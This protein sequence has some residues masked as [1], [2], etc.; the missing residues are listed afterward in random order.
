MQHS[1]KCAEIKPPQAYSKAPLKH[2]QFHAFNEAVIIDHIE[3][4][5]VGKTARGFK[6]ILTI[7][8]GWSNYLVAV[9]TRTQKATES[10]ALIRK[11]WIERFGV[12][13]CLLADNHPNFRSHYFE[14]VLAA[15]IVRKYMANHMSAEQLVE[16][17]AVI[18][19]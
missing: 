5:K 17:S 12:P 2:I 14:T 9:P 3:P 4:E 13:Q 19:V 18:G 11:Y 10:I 16:L 6:Y 8:D 15:L 1:Y 7:T